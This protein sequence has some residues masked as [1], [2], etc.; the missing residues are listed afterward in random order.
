MDPVDFELNKA[1]LTICR[2]ILPGGFD[3]SD[4]APSSFR[5]LCNHLDAGGKMTV[6]GGGCEDT[7]YASQD[8]N[9]A[10]RAWHDLCHWRAGYDFSLQ[11]EI[12][13]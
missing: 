11:G 10:F 4:N 9:Q 8:V 1:I 13:T 7:I 2:T 6:F 3:V 12:A 5:A